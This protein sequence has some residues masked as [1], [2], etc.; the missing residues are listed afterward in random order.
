MKATPPGSCGKVSRPRAR[1]W[2]GS[3]NGRAAACWGERD[4]YR[5]RTESVEEGHGVCSPLAA[6]LVGR[7]QQRRMTR[8]VGA[9]STS[10]A[11]YVHVARCLCEC[12]TRTYFIV[13]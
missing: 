13:Y 6:P 12:Q 4:Y 10:S 9:T 11:L 3:P 2:T 7:V 1:R 8:P 5:S